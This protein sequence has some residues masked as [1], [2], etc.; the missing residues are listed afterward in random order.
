MF[1]SRGLVGT[2]PQVSKWFAIWVITPQITRLTPHSRGIYKWGMAR[3]ANLGESEENTKVPFSLLDC[4][5]V[6]SV[7]FNFLGNQGVFHPPPKKS[8]TQTHCKGVKSNQD[9]SPPPLCMPL[10]IGTP[11]AAPTSPRWWRRAPWAQL[12]AWPPSQRPR[13]VWAS[14]RSRGEWEAPCGWLVLFGFGNLEP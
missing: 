2:P 7:D 11:C 1:F 3:A 6:G 10:A 8:K 13:L 5:W 12:R 4:Y 14:G 9:C